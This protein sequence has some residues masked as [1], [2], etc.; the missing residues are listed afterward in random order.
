MQKIDWHHYAIRIA[1]AIVTLVGVFCL[2]HF[3][4][5]PYMV[6]VE[7]YIVK[8]GFWG[9]VLFVTL[10]ILCTSIM[11]PESIFALAAGAL[12]GI[13]WGWFWITIGGIVASLTM[14]YI[15]RHLL[16]SPV[17]KVLLKHQK[18]KKFDEAVSSFRFLTLLRLSPFNFSALSYLASVSKI[19]LTSYMFASVA[20][21]PGFLSTVYIGYAAKHAADLAKT[22]KETGKL[23]TGDSLV[24]EI[25]IY[26]GLVVAVTV[27]IVVAKVA[28]KTVKNSN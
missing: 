17:Q 7:T 27:S 11:F 18:L 22:Y 3:I 19:S 28:L 15:G 12:F 1:V 20:M 6:E 13:F 10:F 14:F 24:H 21:I 5:E 9:P 26:G 2:F 25:T 8:L 23:P 16:S 4:L